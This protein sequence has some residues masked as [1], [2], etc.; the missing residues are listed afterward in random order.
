MLE[1]K[2]DLKNSLNAIPFFKDLS[3]K[4]FHA[5]VCESNVKHFNKNQMVFM[6]GEPVSYVF[7]ILSGWFK[8]SNIN[9]EGEESGV[10]MRT[11]G[12]LIGF[13]P[14]FDGGFYSTFAVSVTESK[15]LA[16]PAKTIKDKSKYDIDLLARITGILSWDLQDREIAEACFTQKTTSRRVACL[17][18]RLSSYM[19]GKGG[20]FKLPYGKSVAATQLGIDQAT[21]SRGLANLETFGVSSVGNGEVRINDFSSLA[22]QCCPHCPI[23][24]HQCKGRRLTTVKN[25]TQGDSG[26]KY[27]HPH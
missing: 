22:E 16:I 10:Q 2:N 6:Q 23:M 5:L 26:D 13:H 14:M 18:L 11:Y 27:E 8:I 9:E 24:G 1:N 15:A 25:V 12:D 20:T 21:F 19:K 17:L 7:C 4:D 3:E